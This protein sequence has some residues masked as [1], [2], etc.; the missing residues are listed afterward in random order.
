M[1]EKTSKTG[2]KSRDDDDLSDRFWFLFTFRSGS[3]KLEPSCLVDDCGHFTMH[4][5]VMRWLAVCVCALIRNSISFRRGIVRFGKK[6]R[7]LA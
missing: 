2:R 5:E 7:L 1:A 3:G 4:A 6:A